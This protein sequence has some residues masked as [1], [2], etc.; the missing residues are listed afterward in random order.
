ML[1]LQFCLLIIIIFFIKGHSIHM[2]IIH[3]F[4][5]VCVSNQHNYDC[6]ISLAL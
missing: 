6:E 5:C 3:T 2:M 1:S 4:F